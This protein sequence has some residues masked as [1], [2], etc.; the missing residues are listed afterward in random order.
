MLMLMGGQK[1]GKEKRVE[2][3]CQC[4]TDRFS[5]LERL[6]HLCFFRVEWGSMEFN[7]IL[8]KEVVD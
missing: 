1:E 4:T 5:N 7:L 8:F 2:R 3:G 6:S